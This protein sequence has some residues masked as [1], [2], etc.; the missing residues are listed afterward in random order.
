M[1]KNHRSAPAVQLK[2]VQ[3]SLGA[4]GKRSRVASLSCCGEVGGEKEKSCLPD[5]VARPYRQLS[6]AVC[7]LAAS[8][9][10]LAS[11]D[12]SAL[13]AG[14][15]MT[16]ARSWPRD[17]WLKQQQQQLAGLTVRKSTAVL[18]HPSCSRASPYLA[19]DK[20]SMDKRKVACF[21]DE[22][23]K[24][25]CL[26]RPLTLSESWGDAGWGLEERLAIGPLVRW[27]ERFAR[28]DYCTRAL[29]SR[30]GSANHLQLPAINVQN[31]ER[32]T[33]TRKTK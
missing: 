19:L 2:G 4:C 27:G 10:V 28:E 11:L 26:G 5:P 29:L 20:S 24:L 3:Q 6:L 16:A 31:Y 32:L 15:R 21:A 18:A 9:A 33:S 1:A 8:Q 7:S 14:G 22:H 12:E 30:S 13:L 23:E 17:R 25:E